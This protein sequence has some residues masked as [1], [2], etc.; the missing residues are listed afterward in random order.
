MRATVALLPPPHPENRKVKYRQ[1]QTVNGPW[2]F[3]FVFLALKVVRQA[4]L[5][6][7]AAALA[8]GFILSYNWFCS[9]LMLAHIIKFGPA[10]AVASK[11]AGEFVQTQIMP[12]WQ[13]RG[14]DTV[15]VCNRS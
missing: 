10:I 1:L 15:E 11:F 3:F 8:G 13:L 7:W 4:L 9:L 2:C 6:V 12:S 14:K 5:H